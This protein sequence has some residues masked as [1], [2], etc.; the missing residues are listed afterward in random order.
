MLNKEEAIKTLTEQLIDT[1]FLVWVIIYYNT[2]LNNTLTCKTITEFYRT[3]AVPEAEWI[4][5][6]KFNINF[7]LVEILD[8][9]FL[10]TE[11]TSFQ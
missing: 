5:K 1:H 2:I 3:T 4:V 6:E 9:L 8:S 7:K 10:E 11:Q